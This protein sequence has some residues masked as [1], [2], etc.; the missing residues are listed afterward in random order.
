MKRKTKGSTKERWKKNRKLK[1]KIY[2]YCRA[3]DKLREDEE[4]F[5]AQF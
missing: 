5:L 3:T 4:N 2:Y 1:T